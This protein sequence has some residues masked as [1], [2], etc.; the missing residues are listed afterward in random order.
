MI[1]LSGVSKLYGGRRVVDRLDLSLT[2]GSF[3]VIVG[4]PAA[5]SLRPCG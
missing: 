3:N 1:T 4:P 2:D 5:A